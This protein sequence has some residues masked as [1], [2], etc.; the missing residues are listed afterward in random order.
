MVHEQGSVLGCS[1]AESNNFA[2]QKQ[3]RTKYT[4]C[5][6]MTPR[7]GIGLCGIVWGVGGHS[8]TWTTL[9]H[10]QTDQLSPCLHVWSSKCHIV[11]IW[12]SSSETWNTATNGQPEPSMDSIWNLTCKITTNHEKCWA[13]FAISISVTNHQKYKHDFSIS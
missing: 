3:P 13:T 4:A 10:H 1:A 7:S 6:K 5:E 2:G 8:E 12:P 11:S 9:L